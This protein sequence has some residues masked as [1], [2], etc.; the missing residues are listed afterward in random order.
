M[1]KIHIQRTHQLGLQ[2]ARQAALTW[3]EKAQT[4]FEMRCTYHQGAQQ[5]R[6]TFER[7]GVQ[8]TLSITAQQFELEAQLGFLASAFKPRIE[9]EL[10]AQFDALLLEPTLGSES[11]QATAQT[12]ALKKD[13]KNKA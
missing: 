13:K 11:T 2:A 1:S 10:Q 9:A 12:S 6:V 5:D 7:S 3:S 4:K 8:G